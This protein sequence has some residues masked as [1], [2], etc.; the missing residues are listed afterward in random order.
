M[1]VVVCKQIHKYHKHHNRCTCNTSAPNT[2][3]SHKGFKKITV[4]FF[5]SNFLSIAILHTKNDYLNEPE[6][7]YQK[8]VSLLKKKSFTNSSANSYI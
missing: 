6:T 1:I 8:N 4:V 5:L 7:V 3:I 2:C